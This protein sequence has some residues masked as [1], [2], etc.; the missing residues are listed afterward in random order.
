MATITPVFAYDSDI[1]AATI[2]WTGLSTAD[3]ADA[4]GPI[5]GGA[6][7][8]AS[9][10]LTGT[11]GSATVVLQASNNGADFT[12]LKDRNGNNV[13]GTANVWFELS[14]SALYLKPS[15]SGGTADNVDIVVT[16]RGK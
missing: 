12:T 5:K 10:Q 6:G 2:T 1:D 13:S 11:W 4:Y 15:S 8:F 7:Q 3:T 9:V 16:L 14:T